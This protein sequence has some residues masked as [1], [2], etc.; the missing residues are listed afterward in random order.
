MLSF[1][2]A[3]CGVSSALFRASFT[4]FADAFRSASQGQIRTRTRISTTSSFSLLG[5]VAS[6]LSSFLL[7]EKTCACTL[8]K[9]N[10][11]FSHY[12]Y[13]RSYHLCRPTLAPELCMRLSSVASY[14]ENRR[15]ASSRLWSFIVVE[16]V[17]LPPRLALEPY[18]PDAT[19]HKLEA[20]GEP[21]PNR[22]NHG[23][24]LSTGF[25]TWSCIQGLLSPY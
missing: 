5:S 20:T 10:L 3:S 19:R 17:P 12:S 25:S 16:Q 9:T 4:A 22:R 8:P 18:G 14:R 21:H 6:Q 2:R 1:L 13:H 11:C 23:A 24:V 7:S 15:G